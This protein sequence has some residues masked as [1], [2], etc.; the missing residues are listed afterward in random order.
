MISRQSAHEGDKVVSLT[1]LPPLPPALRSRPQGHSAAGRIKSMKNLNGPIGNLT[2]DISACSAVPQ[3]PSMRIYICMHVCL[4]VD[5]R[6]SFILAL[7][8]IKSS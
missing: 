5:V 3:Y 4:G 7:R 8:V 6:L 2:R 1:H